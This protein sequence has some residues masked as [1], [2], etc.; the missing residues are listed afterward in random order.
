MSFATLSVRPDSWA[1]RM[2]PPHVAIEPIIVSRR[3]TAAVPLEITAVETS[4][5][6]P[7]KNAV[8]QDK[9]IIPISI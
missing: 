5:M 7:V 2:T 6:L 3:F 1:T 8:M 4:D 9:K